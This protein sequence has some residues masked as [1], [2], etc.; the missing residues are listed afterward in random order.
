M[1]VAG[2]LF[3]A[4]MRL[5][6][7]TAGMTSGVEA[8]DEL[9]SLLALQ[10]VLEQCSYFL[11]KPTGQC[12][13]QVMV[14]NVSTEDSGPYL[15]PSAIDFVNDARIIPSFHSTQSGLFHRRTS[16]N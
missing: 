9:L 7:V 16:V 1:P 13:G 10:M 14:S 6:T 2:L 15:A 12:T 5:R 8:V 4:R 11:A 3:L